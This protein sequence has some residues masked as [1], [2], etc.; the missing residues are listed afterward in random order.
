VKEFLQRLDKL[1]NRHGRIYFI[2]N[3]QSAVK[4]LRPI[5]CAAGAL[6]LA[7]GSDAADRRARFAV[8][9]RDASSSVAAADAGAELD[10]AESAEAEAM[11]EQCEPATEVA[12]RRKSAS[13][14]GH[15]FGVRWSSCESSSNGCPETRTSRPTG[16]L[17]STA[18]RGRYLAVH[19]YA[20]QNTS[21][22]SSTSGVD[23]SMS[24]SRSELVWGGGGGKRSAST[25][26]GTSSSCIG[27]AVVSS[28]DADCEDN[29]DDVV[30]D[31]LSLYRSSSFRRAI[32][33]GGGGSES[34]PPT[35]IV[36]NQSV[37]R[38]GDHHG[39]T[40]TRVTPSLTTG[41]RL[42]TATFHNQQSSNPAVS[43]RSSAGCGRTEML[44]NP[45]VSPDDTTSTVTRALWDL[46]VEANTQHVEDIDPFHCFGLSAELG[47]GGCS[48]A[49]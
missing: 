14:A 17:T 6:L 38:S 26:G 48:F 12:E 30:D 27:V 43:Y 2:Q 7:P 34:G 37:D 5:C 40:A 32:E 25:A 45:C 23:V 49:L 44:L 8:V 42:S 29:C 13:N 10:V 19:R 16:T 28:V 31:A 3:E 36:A 21:T 20:P 35:T 47:Y 41:A 15:L 1:I 46:N 11:H 22:G 9:G 4:S 39:Y 24:S 18:R 33:R